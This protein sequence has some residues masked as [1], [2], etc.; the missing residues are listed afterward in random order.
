MSDDRPSLAAGAGSNKCPFV[1]CQ[2]REVERVAERIF[3]CKKCLRLSVQCENGHCNVLNRA[4]SRHCRRCN[5]DMHVKDWVGPAK[6]FWSACIEKESLS[7]LGPPS[8]VA[9]LPRLQAPNSIVEMA[10]FHGLLFLH[11]A[12]GFITALHPF[13]KFGDPLIWSVAEKVKC[14]PTLRPFKPVLTDDQKYVLFS[15]PIAVHSLHLW[16]LPD[17]THDDE[18]RFHCVVSLAN[19]GD[20]HLV[21]PPISL[22]GQQFG[23][24]AR[25]E[26]HRYFWRRFD[27]TPNQKLSPTLTLPI[28]GTPCQIFTLD[29]QAI[30]ISTPQGHWVWKR[31]HALANKV[32]EIQRTWEAT[33][34]QQLRLDEEHHNPIHFHLARQVLRPYFSD[35]DEMVSCQWIFAIGAA[36]DYE[37]FQYKIDLIREIKADLPQAIDLHG[38]IPV[39]VHKDSSHSIVVLRDGK[40]LRYVNGRAGSWPSASAGVGSNII[41]LIFHDPLMIIVGSERD[42][43]RTLTL[44]SLHHPNQHQSVLLGPIQS[45]PLVWANWLFTLERNGDQLTLVRRKI[46]LRPSVK[47]CGD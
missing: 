13:G 42:E 40:L 20:P 43:K 41:G 6:Q 7:D 28:Q 45:D 37:L 18:P 47:T 11:Q 9:E 19:P 31:E 25:D 15:T 32:E 16:S 8:P 24:I 3:L 26:D 23:L 30:C 35:D 2:E 1:R 12:G 21:A 38:A 22:G 27:L 33:P 29:T 44:R 39:G 34:R 17:W 10:F 4:F 14:R 46:G 36:H 5:D